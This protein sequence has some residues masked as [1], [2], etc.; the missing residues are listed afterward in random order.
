MMCFICQ[1]VRYIHSRG[2][3]QRVPHR[4]HTNLA[5]RHNK[6]RQLH[7][8]Q[9]DGIQA[10]GVATGVDEKDQTSTGRTH[11]Q[12]RGPIYPH[13]TE[14]KVFFNRKVMEKAC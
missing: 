7:L 1:R 8:L 2:C 3:F 12:Q 14:Q 5:K 6:C 4:I 11:N 10:D 9:T 13:T